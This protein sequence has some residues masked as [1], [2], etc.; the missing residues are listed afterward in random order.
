MMLQCATCSRVNSGMY[1]AH[2]SSQIWLRSWKT[3]EYKATEQHHTAVQQPPPGTA[4]INT[5]LT[6]I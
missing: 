4:L 2:D 6:F 1:G 5:W 3:K